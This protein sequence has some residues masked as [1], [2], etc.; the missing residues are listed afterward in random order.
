MNR[1][2]H[3]AALLIVLCTAMAACN[4][5]TCYD[6]GSSLPLVTF[7][8]SGSQQQVP[9]LTIMGIGAPG[10]SLLVD[11]SAI[12][13][14]Y[15][16]LR[17]SVN[18]TS[19]VLKR[20]GILDIEKVEFLDTLTIDYEAIEFFHSA[21]CGAMYNFNIKR[22]TCTDN[23]IDSVTLLTTLITNAIAP[24][25]RIHFTNLSQR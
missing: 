25:L 12:K 20:W 7:Y 9:G 18:S 23:A 22:V 4:N 2:T 6:N 5:D 3:I 21:E 1:L 19:F 13:E 15:L 17:A 10:D 14:V 11:S 8:L 24:S 16:P